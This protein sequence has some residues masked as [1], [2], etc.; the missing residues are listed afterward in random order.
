MTG[1]EVRKLSEQEIKT[2]I[3]DLRNALFTLRQKSVTDKVDDISQFKKIRHDIARLTTEQTARHH[4][5]NPAKKKAAAPAAKVSK[6]FR[7]MRAV[8]NPNSKTSLA[9]K[10]KAAKPAKVATKK[11]AAK[12]APKAVK[13]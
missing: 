3:A 13:A 12:A 4:K 6:S 9:K 8:A 1:Q 11:S 10:A 7:T 5:A 2:Q